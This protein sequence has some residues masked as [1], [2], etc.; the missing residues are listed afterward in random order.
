MKPLQAEI[1]AALRSRMRQ[2]LSVRPPAI[3]PPS[4]THRVTLSMYLL[5][6]ATNPGLLT[7][8]LGGGTPSQASGLPGPGA[9]VVSR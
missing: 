9:R 6:A 8:A 1:Y 4:A 2:A 5:E 3:T 7:S